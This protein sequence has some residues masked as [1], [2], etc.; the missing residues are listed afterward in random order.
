MSQPRWVFIQS[1]YIV[2]TCLYDLRN[3]SV[4]YDYISYY[5]EKRT[6][7]SLISFLGEQNYL[8]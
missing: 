3:Y 5:G 6:A 8:W 4:E 2:Q 7:I 1:E